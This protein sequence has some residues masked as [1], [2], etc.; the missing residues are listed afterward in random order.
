[1]LVLKEY[2]YGLLYLIH[3]SFT[4]QSTTTLL[5]NPIKNSFF[6]AYMKNGYKPHHNQKKK[7]NVQ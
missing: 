1:M 5:Y 3:T 6:F 4:I 7:H 2:N